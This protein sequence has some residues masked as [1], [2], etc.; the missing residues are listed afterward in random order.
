MTNVSILEGNITK[1]VTVVG[2]G[3]KAVGFLTI[4]HRRNY[5][6]KDG[7]YVTDFIPVKLFSNNLTYAQ[8]YLKKGQRVTITGQV[9][10]YTKEVD[11]KKTSVLEIVVDSI[12]AVPKNTDNAVKD[13]V[14]D[15]SAT[16]GDDDLPF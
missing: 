3:D 4:A 11:G 2:E 10:N 1:E 16:S 12:S 14:V 5:K 13:D 9:R 8:K 6:N 7:E 15:T